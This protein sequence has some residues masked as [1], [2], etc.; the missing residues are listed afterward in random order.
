MQLSLTAL[1]LSAA[2]VQ[3]H[4]TFPRLVI[5]GKPEDKDW[6]V[7]RMTKNAQSKTGIENPTSGDIRCYSSQTAPNV[8]TVPAGATIHFES[9]QQLNHPGPT[10]YYLAKVPAGSSATRWDGSGAVWFKIATTTPTMDK[11][12]QLTWPNQNTYTTVNATIPA[13]TPSGEYLLRVEQIALHMAMQANKAQFY[14]ACSQISITGGGN[15]T[16]G[17]LVSLP[18]AYR[19]NDPGILVNINAIAP[20]AYTPPGPAVWTGN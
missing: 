11:N 4:Y 9:S 12:K 1:L 8:A 14:L 13:A 18:G 6:S 16:P 15:G 17:P 3:A 2:A 5:N 19:S 20:T 10:Q 7:T